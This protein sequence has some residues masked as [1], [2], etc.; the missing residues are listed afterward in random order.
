[1]N[2]ISLEKIKRFRF[3]KKEV[4]S[5]FGLLLSQ[6]RFFFILFWGIVLV[7]SFNILYKKAYIDIQFISYD[8]GRYSGISKEKS[9]LGKITED[10]DFR[11]SRQK[12]IEHMKYRDPFDFVGGSSTPN[13]TES[14]AGDFSVNDDVSD[15]TPGQW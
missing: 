10:I 7:Y 9:V 2:K 14:G 4:Q 3:T 6:R 8:Y 5:L 13:N 15:I 11:L 1:M 12:E